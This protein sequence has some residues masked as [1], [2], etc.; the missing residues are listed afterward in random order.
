M[1]N[2]NHNGSKKQP[3]WVTQT[4]GKTYFMDPRDIPTHPRCEKEYTR[5]P[6]NV[7]KISL[8]LKTDGYDLS[9]PWGLFRCP[10]ED[11]NILFGIWD[12]YT[13]RDAI[14][15]AEIKYNVH[16]DK[17]P[18]V[19]QDFESMDH[20]I[21][22]IRARQASSRQKNT[23]NNL[24]DS[25]FY[26]EHNS[27]SSTVQMCRDM[28]FSNA[29]VVTIKKVLKAFEDSKSQNDIVTE[30]TVTDMSFF[31]LVFEK[32]YRV[33]KNWHD[34]T[35]HK[36]E[37]K[38]TW[39]SC[40]KVIPYAH[41]NDE[42]Y[43]E[44]VSKQAQFNAESSNLNS[45]KLTG[46]KLTINDLENKI[47]NLKEE[48]KKLRKQVKVFESSMEQEVQKRLF[49]HLRLN[50]K[51][52][53]NDVNEVTD[54]VFMSNSFGIS[55]KMTISKEK[56]LNMMIAKGITYQEAKKQVLVRYEGELIAS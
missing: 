49:E 27:K 48:N 34:L 18:Y 3:F 14:L 50:G 4:A 29:T 40:L 2:N 54:F 21:N 9:K 1:S 13:R 41:L 17:I 44:L 7:S 47:Y 15:E 37:A 8:S 42:Q 6:E 55:E 5:S 23:W 35:R 25:I 46:D 33:I 32:H 12:A 56:M 43:D 36:Q 26:Y 52:A 31:Q 16:I 22:T 53:I 24:K 39:N 30:N 11:G 51:K 38:I 10:D 19:I 45:K 28:E 20:V